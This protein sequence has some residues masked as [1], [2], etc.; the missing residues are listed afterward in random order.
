M[1]WVLRA[2][3]AAGLYQAQAIQ[4]A[5]QRARPHRDAQRERRVLTRSD[6]DFQQPANPSIEWTHNGARFLAPSRSATPSTGL[7]SG[8]TSLPETIFQ[9]LSEKSGALAPEPVVQ[10]KDMSVIA[11]CGDAAEESPDIKTSIRAT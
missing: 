8:P 3:H 2:R 4:V 5:F 9:T 6:I 1:L 10:A 11:R 7:T